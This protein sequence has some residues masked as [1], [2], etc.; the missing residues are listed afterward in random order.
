MP[1]SRRYAHPLDH[2]QSPRIGSSVAQTH[3][4]TRMSTTCVRTASRVWWASTGRRRTRNP[5]VLPGRQTAPGSGRARTLDRFRARRWG[6]TGRMTLTAAGV[7]RQG[8]VHRPRGPVRRVSG[9][10]FDQA[11]CPTYPRAAYG[12]ARV[13]SRRAR[14]CGFASWLLAFWWLA[15]GGHCVSRE[16]SSQRTLTCL[17]CLSCGH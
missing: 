10:V 4:S 17:A 16:P 2:A 11:G 12:R 7:A 15:S 1:R 14:V 5:D 9:S 3:L 8:V 6:K 13:S